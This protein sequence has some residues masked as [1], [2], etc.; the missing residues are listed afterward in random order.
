MIGLPLRGHSPK[1]QPEMQYALPTGS[2]LLLRSPAHCLPAAREKLQLSPR[3][4]TRAGTDVCGAVFK[5]E[6]NF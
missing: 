3:T 4:N 6:E 1:T 2:P 5:R